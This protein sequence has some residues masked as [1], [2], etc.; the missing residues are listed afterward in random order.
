MAAAC[1]AGAAWGQTPEQVQSVQRA[2]RA[3]YIRESAIE[4]CAPATADRFGW[5]KS[6][7]VRCVYAQQDRLANGRRVDR[8]AVAEV[9]FPE[10]SVIAR[11]IVTA[12]AVLTASRP[13]CFSTAVAEG[14][15]TSGFQF[16]VTGNVLED[17]PE[18]GVQKNFFFRNG[19]TVAVAPNVNGRPD[20]LPLDRQQALADTSNED[21]VSIPSGRTRY[22]STTPAQFRAR[23]P[24]ANVPP[25]LA[26]REHRLAWLELARGE[27]LGALASDRNRLL[28]AWL[29][30]NAHARFQT[31]CKAPPP[32]E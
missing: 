2:M 16:A 19:M 18:T 15:A 27:L 22:W 11:W 1:G 12:C 7:V 20:D 21:I 32:T 3:A 17:Q 23:F 13:N 9:V 24:H 31:T 30:A 8:K 28:E 10:P 5:P 4:P 29:C 26:T 14:K 6:I 25:D